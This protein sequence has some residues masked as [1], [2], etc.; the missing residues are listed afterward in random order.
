MLDQKKVVIGKSRGKPS[1]HAQAP[2]L[3]QGGGC[4]L[5]N[6]LSL[7]VALD[8]STSV[9][10]ALQAWERRERPLTDHTQRVSALYSKV[11]TLPPMLRSRALSWLGK[12]KWA[13]AQRMRT[14]FHTPTGTAR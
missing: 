7:A 5:M 11:T 1:G 10:Q 2:N 13:M 14:A 9:E 4:S 8:E 3:G 6:A 12:S